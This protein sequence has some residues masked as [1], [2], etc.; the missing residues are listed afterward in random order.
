M[1][2]RKETKTVV[3]IPKV[4]NKKLPGKNALYFTNI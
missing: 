3:E 4:L 1:E 2:G